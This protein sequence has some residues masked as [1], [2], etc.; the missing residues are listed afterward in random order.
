MA[1][2]FA[3]SLFDCGVAF[4]D[5]NVFGFLYNIIN[6]VQ[7]GIF[8][9]FCDLYSCKRVSECLIHESSLSIRRN[10]Y[11]N[12]CTTMVFRRRKHPRLVTNFAAQ[13]K[14]EEFY[15]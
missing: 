2:I 10:N 8:I 13:F 7:C 4:L 3:R 5:Q 9:L 12:V 15:R 6:C 1:A 14:T 11:V